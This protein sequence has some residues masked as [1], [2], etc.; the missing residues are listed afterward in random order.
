MR[1]ALTSSFP[2]RIVPGVA[3]PHLRVGRTNP[4]GQR[5]PAVLLRSMSFSRAAGGAPAVLY[6]RSP[7][8]K[9]LDAMER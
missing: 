6:G 4:K 3:R 2:T 7:F 8:S 9:T 1:L 5:R